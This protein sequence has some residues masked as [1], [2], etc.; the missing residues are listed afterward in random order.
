M[1]STGQRSTRSM[2]CTPAPGH[3]ARMGSISTRPPFL[4]VLTAPASVPTG[5]RQAHMTAVLTFVAR[6]LESKK[7]VLSLLS[8]PIS[9]STLHH[10]SA[11]RRKPPLRRWTGNTKP[12]TSPPPLHHC[13]RSQGPHVTFNCTTQAAS[14]TARRAHR[15]LASRAMEPPRHCHRE[16]PTSAAP[17]SSL[18][19]GPLDHRHELPLMIPHWLHAPPWTATG[20]L[21]PTPQPPQ[22]VS[23]RSLVLLPVFPHRRL[24]STARVAGQIPPSTARSLPH[25]KLGLPACDAWA[26]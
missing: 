19:N 8:V 23:H 1:F 2:T 18:N 6:E 22:M 4:P 26:S 5:H 21:P 24:P 13:C 15:C 25:P 3:R 17:L 9:L 7:S 14:S 10:C 12:K 11:R 20:E 16:A